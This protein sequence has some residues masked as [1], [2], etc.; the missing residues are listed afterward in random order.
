MCSIA[1]KN[2]DAPEIL[3]ESYSKAYDLF[4]TDQDLDADD[5]D[6]HESWRMLSPRAQRVYREQAGAKRKFF[7]KTSIVILLHP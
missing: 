3:E 6:A 7:D 2:A 4:C 1:T 5:P